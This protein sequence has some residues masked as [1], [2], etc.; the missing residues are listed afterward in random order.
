MSDYY[1]YYHNNPHERECEED[2]DED[3]LIEEAMEEFI[4]DINDYDVID[5]AYS[6]D[7]K[8]A[9]ELHKKIADAYYY[10]FTPDL[11]AAAKELG[12][13]MVDQMEKHVKKDL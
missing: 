3:E 8:R 1:E 4:R 10:N 2:K 13:L 11:I 7:M 6:N 5:Y 9:N 12:K